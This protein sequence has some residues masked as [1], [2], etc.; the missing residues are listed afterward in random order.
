MVEHYYVVSSLPYLLFPG[1][2]PFS[3]RDFFERSAIWLKGHDLRQFE[4]ART[5][6]QDISPAEVSHGFLKRWFAFENTIRNELVHFRAKALGLT[7]ES[8]IRPDLG[9]DVNAIAPTHQALQE[10]SPYQR[11]WMLL[12]IRW[13]FL[14]HWSVGHHFDLTALMIYGLKLQLL[15]RLESFEEEKGLKTLEIIV[16]RSL[17]EP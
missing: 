1:K 5:D 12:Q 8:Y 10:S 17:D 2:A 7:A 4:L 15:Q 14:E 11:E 16:E 6:T 3:Y 13:D 9:A